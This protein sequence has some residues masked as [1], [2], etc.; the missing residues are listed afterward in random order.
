M[1]KKIISFIFRIIM[2]VPS[3]A[4]FLRPFVEAY[5]TFSPK[6]SLEVA[7]ETMARF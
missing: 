2:Q 1:D 4:E 6:L 3:D 7:E 5:V